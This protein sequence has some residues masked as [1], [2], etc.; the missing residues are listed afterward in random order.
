M[1][2]QESY[3]AH[4]VIV[5]V[6]AIAITLLTLWLLGWVVYGAVLEW[7]TLEPLSVTGI[8][9]GAASL[10]FAFTLLRRWNSLSGLILNVAAGVIPIIGVALSL[11][12]AGLK[13][14][15][16]I[17]YTQASAGI[18]V[19]TLVLT[20][21][22]LILDAIGQIKSVWRWRPITWSSSA[23]KD[24]GSLRDNTGTEGGAGYV[25]A[26]VAVG[27][28]VGDGGSDD[29]GTAVAEVADD[30]GEEGDTGDYRVDGTPREVV[31]Q[32]RAITGPGEFVE[33]VPLEGVAV[34]RE[35][36]VEQ[37]DHSEPEE[38]GSDGVRDA[39]KQR[40][41]SA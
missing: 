39:Q 27:D 4:G 24:S 31:G 20:V 14:P 34:R 6:G 17:P 28:A 1:A 38:H 22:A 12:S 33:G 16:V 30:G 40:G 32:E 3:A 37:P 13:P 18:A 41:N 9:F 23:P 5:W 8:A 15:A 35:R 36:G 11:S 19:V 2:K 25:G 7:N 10:R 21:L 29:G 26:A